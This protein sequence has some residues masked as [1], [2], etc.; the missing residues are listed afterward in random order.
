MTGSLDWMPYRSR[1]S[2]GHRLVDGIRYKSIIQ[3]LPHVDPTADRCNVESPVPVEEFTIANEPVRTMSEAFGACFA[4]GTSASSPQLSKTRVA[5]RVSHTV[6]DPFQVRAVAEAALL[7]NSA[8]AA[9]HA[10]E[11]RARDVGARRTTTCL[12]HRRARGIPPAEFSQS[13]HGGWFRLP[14]SLGMHHAV[15]LRPPR[16][17]LQRG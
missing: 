15:G 16:P 3:T 12:V 11:R 9:V 13:V 5:Q 8:M 7:A 1:H 17:A 14:G 6:G 2:V 10:D 4:E